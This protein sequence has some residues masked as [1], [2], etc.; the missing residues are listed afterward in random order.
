MTFARKMLL[1]PINAIEAAL[2]PRRCV[3]CGVIAR[4]D[5]RFICAGCTRDLPWIAHS[6][7]Y[8]AVPIAGPLPPG[9][10]CANCQLEPPLLTAAVA[11]LHYSFPVDAAIKAFKFHRKLNYQP[12]FSDILLQASAGLP[13]GIDALLPV[14]LHR[15]RRIRRGFN[16]AAELAAPVA[17]AMLLETL[18]NVARVSATPYQSGLDAAE[19]R[20][21]LK[22]A[23]R[24]S[25]HINARHV[26][27]IDDVIT[28]GATCRQLARVLL[29]K[30]AAEVSVLALAR[31]SKDAL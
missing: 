27:I 11:P 16:Q 12:A 9:V 10:S 31:A 30:G 20:R 28:T 8:C 17:K 13:A 3:F 2:M 23:F 14:P 24:V 6:C 18:N 7:R 19:R 1:R 25:G 21:N 4:D 5:E 26:L 22:S 29:D 15:W